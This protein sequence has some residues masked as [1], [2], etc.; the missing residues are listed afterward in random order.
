MA[1][2]AGASVVEEKETATHLIYQATVSKPDNEHCTPLQGK[3]S[4]YSRCASWFVKN[5]M[6]THWCIGGTLLHHIILGYQV[7]SF[8]Q[9]NCMAMLKMKNQNGKFQMNGLNNPLNSTNG[10]WNG[11]INSTVKVTNQQ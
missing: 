4:P 10:C 3:I 11:I 7:I 6:D 9:I 2:S 5:G 8:H 1:E